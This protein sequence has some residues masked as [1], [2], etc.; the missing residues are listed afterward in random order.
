MKEIPIIFSTPM[1]QAILDGRKTMTRRIIKPQPM[2][3]IM[4]QKG[5]DALITAGET[6]GFDYKADGWMWKGCR[7]LPWPDGLISRCPY[8][9]AGDTVLWV[10][11]TWNVDLSGGLFDSKLE[12]IP[13]YFYKASEEE[14]EQLRWKPSIHMPKSACRIWLEVVSVKVERLKE[15]SVRDCEAEGIQ[16]LN[17]SLMQIVSN[18]V[19]FRDYSKKAELLNDGLP[20]K[21]SFKS[22]WQTIHGKDSW[23]LNPWLWVIEFRRI[24][25]KPKIK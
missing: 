13:H 22:L 12:G 19:E 14:P 6:F 10:R 3:G 2:L 15:I 23:E 9:F 1:V 17:Q 8:G 7:Y 21:D 5:K 18:G 4:D 11:E 20:A 25:E 24:D 16:Q